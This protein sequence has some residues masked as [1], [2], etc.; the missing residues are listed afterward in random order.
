MPF[1]DRGGATCLESGWSAR[2]TKICRSIGS[3]GELEEKNVEIGMTSAGA[4]IYC[5]EE[6]GSGC[7][8]MLTMP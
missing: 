8:N 7:R 4:E 6:V 2:G 5:L 1:F 3:H